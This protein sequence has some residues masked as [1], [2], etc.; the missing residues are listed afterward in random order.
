MEK[1]IYCLGIS[2]IS[3]LKMTYT[4]NKSHLNNLF[5]FKTTDGTKIKIKKAARSRPGESETES[6][7]EASA[8]APKTDQLVVFSLEHLKLEENLGGNSLDL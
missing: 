4:V 6:E 7:A 1:P 8:S 5:L 3:S 2:I